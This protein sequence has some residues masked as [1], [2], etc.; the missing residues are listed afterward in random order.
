VDKVN[1]PSNE[2]IKLNGSGKKKAEGMGLATANL[3]NFE[4]ALKT[5]GQTSAARIDKKS[6][7]KM[8]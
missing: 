7:K 1:K 6:I 8:Q 4:E 5:V 3:S 2:K